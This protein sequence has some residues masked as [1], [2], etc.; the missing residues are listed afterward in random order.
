MDYEKF[1]KD[2]ET[3]DDWD[4]IHAAQKVPFHW[5]GEDVINFPK[6]DGKGSV[7]DAAIDGRIYPLFAVFNCSFTIIDV[8]A[9]T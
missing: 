2:L 3:K 6:L 8:N 9:M 5:A 4:R 1:K 7:N